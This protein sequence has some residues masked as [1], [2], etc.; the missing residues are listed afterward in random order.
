MATANFIVSSSTH[1]WVDGVKFIARATIPD[2]LP[3]FQTKLG[4]TRNKV[5]WWKIHFRN[6]KDRADLAAAS[7]FSLPAWDVYMTWNPT[8][9]DCFPIV[10]E[11]CIV[12]DYFLYEVQL[13]FKPIQGIKA[14]HR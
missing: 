7:A 4:H 14:R 5:I 8:K 12:F 11:M 2:I 1:N 3:F 10:G 13:E 9:D 6:G